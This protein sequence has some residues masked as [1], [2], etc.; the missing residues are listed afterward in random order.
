MASE[1][2]REEIFGV[3]SVMEES[4]KGLLTRE[5]PCTL[6]FTTTRLIVTKGGVRDRLFRNIFGGASLYN[7][8]TA[9]ARERL[10]WAEATPDGV[11][12][13][14]EQHYQVGYNEICAMEVEK[15]KL[16]VF[17]TN[18]DVPAHRF[19]LAHS[20]SNI[21]RLSEEVLGL[22]RAIVPDKL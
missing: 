17:G 14:Y 6:W 3:L 12:G 4:G 20:R 13:S 1:A 9:N 8:F 10:K 16:L 15:G 19:K 2:A 7:R 18:L 5:D 21:E 22:L 11:L